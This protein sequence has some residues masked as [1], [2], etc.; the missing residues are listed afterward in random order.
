MAH[1]LPEPEILELT[2]EQKQVA[3]KSFPRT[4][5]RCLSSWRADYLKRAG[6]VE[7][8]AKAGQLQ[9]VVATTGLGAGV[10]FSMRSVMVTDREY[11]VDDQLL[12]VRHDELLQMFGRA[13]RRGKDTRGF[14]IVAP[15]Q[16]RLSDARPL[17]LH[18]STT[19]DWPVLLKEMSRAIGQGEDHITA[20]RTLAD[21]LFS[22]E[23][24]RLGFREALGNFRSFAQSREEQIPEDDSSRNEVIEMLNS[25]GLWER[26]GGQTK[27]RLQMP[28]YGRMINGFPLYPCQTLLGGSRWATLAVLEAANLPLM[29][30][31]YHSQYMWMNRWAS[32]SL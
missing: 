17:R 29:A 2:A 11:R 19:L 27:A 18:R 31:K 3:G 15:R 20:A 26:R 25:S 7:P 21:R 28:G 12:Q 5:R 9:V 16:A 30:G 10:N 32:G 4:G 22:E 13:G 6:V 23:H 24:V 14:V 1:E 8:L